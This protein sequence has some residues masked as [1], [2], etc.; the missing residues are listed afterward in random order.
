MFAKKQINEVFLFFKG[1][2]KEARDYFSA[3]V[4]SGLFNILFYLLKQGYNAKLYNLSEFNDDEVTRFVKSNNIKTAFIS[5]FMGNHQTSFKLAKTIKHFHKDAI[6][7]LGGPFTV[8]GD[9]IL[10]RVPSI[11]YIIT[12]EGEK[13]SFQLLRFLENKE[14]I[15]NVNGLIYRKGGKILSN[16]HFFYS[17]IDDFFFIPSQ[18]ISYC[19][20]VRNEN[21]AIL[22]TSRGCP[23]SCNFC[24]SPVLWKNSIRYHS[25][26]NLINYIKDLYN[27]LGEI[28][29]SIRDDNFLMNKKRVTEFSKKLAKEQLGLL[30]NTQ[31]SVNFIDEEVASSLAQAGCDQV[32]LGIE[33]ASQRIL[34]FFNKRLCIEDTYKAIATLR[35]HLIR[36]FG[37]FIGGVNETESEAKETCD[38]IKKSGLI[39]GIISPLV[40]YPGTDLSKTIETKDYFSNKEILYYAKQSYQKFKKM[41]LASLEEA[42]YNNNFKYREIKASPTTSFLK[43]IVSH[44]Y[45][46]RIDNKPMAEKVLLTMDKKNPWR[47]KLLKEL[48]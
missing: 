45:Y 14:D 42:F 17:N 10:K 33:S 4:P 22:I 16:Q 29:F 46:L 47:E 20:F 36:P 9:E 38:F 26:S 44:F 7:V 1:P 37:Y 21:F 31:G 5:A 2:E 18:L 48:Y 27:N 3:F 43:E 28:Y 6:T 30:W 24:S 19:N 13:S 40:I 25:I 34:I 39:D 35:K 41:Y 12:G 8:L 23:Y 32:Q 11:D 15:K